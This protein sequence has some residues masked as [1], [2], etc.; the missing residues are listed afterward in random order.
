M[1][2]HYESTSK[3][4]RKF[5]Y[6]RHNAF[7]GRFR[8]LGGKWYLEI[9]PTYRF[10]FNGKDLDRFHEKRLSGIKPIEKN[11]S[12]LSQL[13]IWQAILRAPWTKVDR[14]RLL[15]FA[16]AGVLSLRTHGRRF[17]HAAGLAD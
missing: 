13:L 8:W 1:V 10:T 5:T 17:T 16:L 4:G 6:Y 9:T 3:D 15:E 11:R 7:Q 12:V 2:S 14:A